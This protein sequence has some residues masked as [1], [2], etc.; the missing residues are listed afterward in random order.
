MSATD[1]GI[2]VSII[3]VSGLA[4]VVLV[5]LADRLGRRHML[6]VTLA[7]LAVFT[8]LTAAAWGIVSFVVLSSLSRV[9]LSAEGV[10]TGVVIV[11]S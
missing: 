9:F 1:F 8:G 6:L 2:A 7:G 5:G 4:A 3:R 10:M 11:G